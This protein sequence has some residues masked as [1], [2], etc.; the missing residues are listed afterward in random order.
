MEEVPNSP[1]LTVLERTVLVAALG[2]DDEF[3]AALLAQV[4]E[5]KAMV[6][7]PSGVG[8]VTKLHVPGELRLSESTDLN[9]LPLVVGQHPDLPSGAEFVL[10]I[11][12]G[13]LN[14][15][16]AFCYEGMWPRDES[17]FEI[18]SRS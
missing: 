2:N 14:S 3:G 13:K 4:E 15:I 12:N 8:F 1:D 10:Q 11:K 7:T 6:R 17:L 18:E 16:E 5:A 9:S